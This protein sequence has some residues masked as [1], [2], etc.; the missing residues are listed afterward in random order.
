MRAHLQFAVISFGA[1]VRLVAENVASDIPQNTAQSYA[2]LLNK[3]MLT[4]PKVYEKD[5]VYECY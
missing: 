3:K 4:I 1:Q 2:T 5:P